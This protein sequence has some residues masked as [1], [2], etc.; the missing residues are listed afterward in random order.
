MLTR[1]AKVSIFLVFFFL[2]TVL[3]SIAY[4]Q[5]NV[6]NVAEG[7]TFFQ[8]LMAGGWV[9]GV[10]LLIS[11]VMIAL[12]IFC[13][14]W[15][16]PHRYVPDEAKRMVHDQVVNRKFREAFMFCDGNQIPFCN[17]VASGLKRAH[18]FSEGHLKK[19][20]D[21]FSLEVFYLMEN[22]RSVMATSGLRESDK[23]RSLINWFSNI[24][25]IAPMLGLLGTVLG[26]IRAFGAIAFKVETGKPVLLSSAISQAMVT[27]AGGL[28]I[29]IFC[30]M[31]FYYFTGRADNI[32]NEMESSAEEVTEEIE[33]A[34]RKN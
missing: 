5:G 28:I 29:G 7:F 10:I 2:L 15:L 6:Q 19:G 34:F 3:F 26:M 25:I 8:L 22:I 23:L 16:K 33:Q 13:F 31:I 17:V 32:I 9:M 4:A 12:G 1:H 20:G 11:F 18:L 14:L 21:T 24:G 30:M 27:T